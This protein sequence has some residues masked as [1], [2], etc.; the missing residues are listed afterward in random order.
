MPNV[1]VHITVTLVG[2]GGTLIVHADKGLAARPWGKCRRIALTL[3]CCA[4]TAFIASKHPVVVVT[5]YRHFLKHVPML[6][7][8]ALIIETENVHPCIIGTVGP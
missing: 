6:D 3:H 7:D 5:L 2:G 4:R 8:L 1:Q